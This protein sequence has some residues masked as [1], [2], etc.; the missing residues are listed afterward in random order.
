MQATRER[1]DHA[2]TAVNQR[3]SSRSGHGLLFLVLSETCPDA[4]ERVKAL[5]VRALAEEWEAEVQARRRR[6]RFRLIRGRRGERPFP[7]A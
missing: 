7:I 6:R 3:V 2:P 1:D 5:S 4:M